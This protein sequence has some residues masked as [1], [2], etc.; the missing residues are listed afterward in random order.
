M[1]SYYTDYGIGAPTM[2]EWASAN[3][4]T[5][6]MGV[7]TTNDMGSSWDWGAIVNTAI[8]TIGNIFGSN[9]SSNPNQATGQPIVIQTPP[10]E[11]NNM[12]LMLGF[13][14]VIG[15]MLFKK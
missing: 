7:S 1:P 11:N 8:G 12:M 6:G 4:W 2:E 5:G 3:N 15:L 14:L 9:G 13:V 10:S